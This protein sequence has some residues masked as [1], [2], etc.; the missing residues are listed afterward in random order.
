MTLLNKYSRDLPAGKVV[1]L[2]SPVQGS[3]MAK[4]FCQRPLGRALLGPV[5][6]GLKSGAQVCANHQIGVIAGVGS[7]GAGRL[8]GKLPEPN[9]GTVSLAE[10]HIDSASS[11][12]VPVSHFGLILSPLVARETAYFLKKGCFQA[13]SENVD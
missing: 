7:K 3:V 6:A 2:G 12:S 11:I 10:T 8:I 9:D 4:R 5:R 1:M 13:V